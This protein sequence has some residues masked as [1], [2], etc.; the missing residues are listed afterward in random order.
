MATCNICGGTAFKAGPSG[1]LAKNGQ[2]PR[3]MTCSSLERH[4]IIRQV[5][6]AMPDKLLSKTSVLQFSQDTGAPKERFGQYEISVFEG[7]NSLDMSDIDRPDDSYDWVVANHVLEHVEDDFAA[8]RELFRIL[9]PQGVLQITV[10]V[11]ASSVETFEF[12]RAVP[13]SHYHWRGYGSDLPL[14]FKDEFEGKFGLAV[15][16]TD[17]ITERW[18]IVYLLTPSREK[19][20]E[21]SEAF[22]AAK[23][24]VLRCC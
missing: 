15:I 14:R 19:M 7:V 21:L 8:M 4:R 9:K 18:D 22:F 11:T 20:L 3:C 2:K 12:G 17:A 24:P 6:D 23:L 5:Y 13:E 16:G 10:P 1:R